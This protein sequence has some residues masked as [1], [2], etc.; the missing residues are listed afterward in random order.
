[1]RRNAGKV[2]VRIGS[3][4]RRLRRIRGWSQEALAERIEI[5][6]KHVGRMERGQ[7]NI[8]VDML[9][10]LATVME[11]DIAELVKGGSTDGASPS[12][13]PIREADLTRLEEALRIVEQVRRAGKS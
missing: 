3:N 2:R 4:I 7:V 13:Y 9:A 6:E 8:K 11:C 5:T 12:T 10:S 1:M